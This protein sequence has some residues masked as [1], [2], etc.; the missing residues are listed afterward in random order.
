MADGATSIA[1]MPSLPKFSLLGA[2]VAVI[3]LLA[4]PAGAGATLVYTKN[5]MHPA[6]FAANDNGGGAFRVGSGSSPTVS[7]DGDVIAYQREGS[8]GKRDLMLAAAEGG[9]TQAV[10]PNLQDAFYLTFSPDSKLIAAVQGPELGKRKLV[11]LDVTSGTLL[12]T[13]ASGYFSGV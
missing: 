9:G 12:R 1:V 2:L 5:L 7:P 6:V 4:L 3:A 8:G 11:L 10:L 13:V